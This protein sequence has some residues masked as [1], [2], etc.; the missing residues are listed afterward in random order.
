MCSNGTEIASCT[1]SAIRCIVLVQ[2]TIASAPATSS[3]VAASQRSRVAASQF[4]AAW[5]VSISAKSKLTINSGAE[6]E[7]PISPCTV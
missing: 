6:C 7:P 4:P 1:A 5:S 2:M 3:R